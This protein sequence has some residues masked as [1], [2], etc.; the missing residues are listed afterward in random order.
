M[1]ATPE[2]SYTMHA[3]YSRARK[4]P[5]CMEN[6]TLL[7]GRGGGGVTEHNAKFRKSGQPLVFCIC[8][9]GGQRETGVTANQWRSFITVLGRTFILAVGR[10]ESYGGVLSP[11]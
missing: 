3:G 2:T 4:G 8:S 1:A 7:T 5:A 6:Q 10:K 9:Q 11:H